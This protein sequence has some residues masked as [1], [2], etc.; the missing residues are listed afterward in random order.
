MTPYKNPHGLTA[1]LVGD[2]LVLPTGRAVPFAE[3]TGW[4]E[5]D[6]DA[7]PTPACLAAAEAAQRVLD[8]RPV[9]VATR[10]LPVLDAPRPWEPDPVAVEFRA[11][12][13]RVRAEIDARLDDG[14]A[15]DT[16]FAILD[17]FADRYSVP[18]QKMLVALEDI[19]ACW[20]TAML[21]EVRTQAEAVIA[22]AEGPGAEHRQ[23]GFLARN[24]AAVR[25]C[26]GRGFVSVGRRSRWAQYYGRWT[27][28]VST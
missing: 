7:T 19:E 23:A 26:A 25:H 1:I 18:T 6:D 12:C 8:A 17:S 13:A 10:V 5:A 2:T 9:V 15:K 20:D 16:Y 3:V 22:W 28:I 24:A 27:A 14:E 21:A 11:R 4:E